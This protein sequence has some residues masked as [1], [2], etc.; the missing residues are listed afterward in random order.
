MQNVSARR[1]ERITSDEEE[2]QR[3]GYDVRAYF[4]FPK[5]GGVS[6]SQRALVT[7]ALGSVANLEYGDSAT[8]W[9]VN[10]GWSRRQN[11]TEHGFFL[12]IEKGEW[13]SRDQVEVEE[14]IVAAKPNARR[15]I[16]YVDDTKNALVFTPSVP[17]DNE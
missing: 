6:A 8:L 7:D 1:L 12:D 13:V 11:T 3:Q 10:L 15:V 17:T 4:A 16:P 2:R 9:R 14:G 5:V